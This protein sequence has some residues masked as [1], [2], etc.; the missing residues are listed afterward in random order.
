VTGVDL[1][2]AM[3]GAAEGRAAERGLDVTFRPGRVEAL[4]FDDT[5]FD[6]VLAVTVLCFVGDPSAA[7]REM[8]RVLRPGGRLVVGDLGR[9]NLWAASRRVRGWLGSRTWRNVHFWTRAELKHQVSIAGL[10]VRETR[11]AIHYPPTP[12]LARRLARID[13]WLSRSRSPGAAFVAISADKP[14]GAV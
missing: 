13:L 9:H 12:G 14:T 3:L 7:F 8:A 5:T 10:C 4:P 6:V 2:P 1:A 11:G